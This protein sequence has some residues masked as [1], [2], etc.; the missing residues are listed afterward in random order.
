MKFFIAILLGL[1][2]FSIAGYTQKRH[3][4]QLIDSLNTALLKADNDVVRRNILAKLSWPYTMIGK[5][6]SAIYTAQTSLQLAHKLSDK[7]GIADANNDLGNV[8][9][10]TGNYPEAISAFLNAIKILEN[11]EDKDAKTLLGWA[12]S[13]L[14]EAY[15]KWGNTAEA[16]KQVTIALNY[17]KETGELYWLGS[18]Y[19]NLGEVYSKQ[20]NDSLALESYRLGLNVAQEANNVHHLI[21]GYLGI[22]NLYALQGKYVNSLE[23]YKAALKYAENTGEQFG[24]SQTYQKIG[25]AYVQLRLPLEAQKWL[26]KALVLS[27]KIGA[28]ETL[29]KSYRTLVSADSL[30]NNYQEAFEHYKL[31]ELY[32]DSLFNEEKLNRIAYLE[33]SY[34]FERQQ[35]SIRLVNEKALAIRDATLESNRREKI[36]FTTGL[37]LLAALGI[38]L[39][40]QSKGRKNS[41]KKLQ[42]LNEELAIANKNKAR[43]F[44]ILNHDLRSP[45]SSLVQFLHLKNEQD[46]MFDIQEQKRLEQKTM[47]S[48]ENLLTSM[49]D[50]LQWSKGQMEHFSPA[51]AKVRITDI[52][53]DNQRY[54]SDEEHI[55]FKYE[56]LENIVLTTDEDYLKTIIRN[57]TSNAIA[58]VRS[59]PEPQ[60]QWRAYR[61]EQSVCIAIM[62]NGEGATK[63][64]FKPLF[65]ATVMSGI[66]SGLGLHL[67]RDL[68]AAIHLDIT[69]LLNGSN[70]VT[71]VLRLEEQR[72]F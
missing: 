69:L 52:F 70:G 61:Q 68:A 60:V 67:I 7:Y 18:S 58:A 30:R 33:M 59:V 65:D 44:S 13:N 5:I 54:F 47:R 57:L 48:A 10:L 19:Y 39:F 63:E 6:D 17:K 25:E 71:V 4:Q 40:L 12:H 42:K 34:G 20:G 1:L 56:N 64:Q 55:A 46:A 32:K 51:F 8:Y 62:D 14:S 50:L 49:E 11:V 36:F 29:K 22:G 24:I 45:V 26:Q 31:Y 38:I 23:S 41:N 35:D 3:G 15:L 21:L 27:R 16:L 72:F 28:K 53:N 9:N 66:K 43:F 2:T 37:A